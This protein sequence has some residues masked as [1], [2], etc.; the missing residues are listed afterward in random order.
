MYTILKQLKILKT[1]VVHQDG[2]ERVLKQTT[3]GTNEDDPLPQ[4]CH[5]SIK[6]LCLKTD[7]KINLPTGRIFYWL[8]NMQ[9][10]NKN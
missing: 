7:V 1:S 8:W 5:F 9:S 6:D 10:S 3:R 2:L 4:E